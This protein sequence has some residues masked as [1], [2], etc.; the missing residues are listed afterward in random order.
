MH[1]ILIEKIR[2]RILQTCHFTKFSTSAIR[3]ILIL[4]SKYPAECNQCN[5][6]KQAWKTSTFRAV[7]RGFLPFLEL[8][9]FCQMN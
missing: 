5:D 7:T 9:D 2:V 1:F 4:L 3:I 8:Q 6:N